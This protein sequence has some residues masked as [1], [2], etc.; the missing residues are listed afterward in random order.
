[1]KSIFLWSS[2]P[3]PPDAKSQTGLLLLGN[4]KELQEQQQLQEL[5]ELEE[6]QQFEELQQSWWQ[7]QEVQDKGHVEFW[8]PVC[9][10]FKQC[11]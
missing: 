4:Q 3:F 11:D 9:V 2:A 7:R 5:E 1:M 6:V 8:S 10:L